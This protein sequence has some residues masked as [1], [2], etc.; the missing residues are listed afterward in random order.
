MTE[1]YM[2]EAQHPGENIPPVADF[3]PRGVHLNSPSLLKLLLTARVRGRRCKRRRRRSRNWRC[4]SIVH[5]PLVPNQAHQAYDIVSVSCPSE[6]L[7]HL[8]SSSKICGHSFSEQAIREFIKDGRGQKLMCPASGCNK[9]ISMGDLD[10]DKAL[11]KKAK[12]AERRAQRQHENS[13]DD[14]VIE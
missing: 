13:D 4:H 7:V 14:E 2:Q 9:P 8:H 3:I 11:E 12:L 5:V 10:Y 6:N 1:H